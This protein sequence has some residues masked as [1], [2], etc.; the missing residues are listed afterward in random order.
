MANKETNKQRT[1]RLTRIHGIHERQWPKGFP[2]FLPIAFEPK[3]RSPEETA[4][5]LA[6]AAALNTFANALKRAAG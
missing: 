2:P 5:L 3:Q 4:E 1:E 6:K